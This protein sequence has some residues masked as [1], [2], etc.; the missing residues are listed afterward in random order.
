MDDF[1][2][3]G[4]SFDECLSNL[5]K[6]LKRFYR[7]FIRDFSKITRPLC[8]LLQKDVKF[9]LD[10]ECKTAF[11]LIKKKLISAPIIQPPDWDYPFEIMCDA[12]DY[13]VGVV[14]GQRINKRSHV[15]YYASKML[16][17]AQSNYTTT[18]K[19][20]LS[21]VYALD[22]FCP[23]LL[24]TKVIVY[25]DHA[26][27]RY[28]LSKKDAKPRLIRWILLLQEFDLE[29]K[30]K[31]GCENLFADH[32]SRIPTLDLDSLPI[33]DEFPDEQFF[34]AQEAY[35]RSR[36]GSL[37][38]WYADIVNF[39]ATGD[40]PDHLP[41]SARDKIQM[42]ES[43]FFWPTL[44]RDAYLCCK[45]CISCQ[46]TGN[47]GPRNQMPLNP[48]L[49]SK[50]TRTNDSKVVVDFVRSNIFVRYGT[51]RAIISDRGTHFCN[52]TVEA[53]FKKY[54]V[55]H[56]T[57][58]AYHPQ[59]NG[60]A[61]ISNREIKLILEKTVNPNR[62]DWSLRLD[63]ALWAYRTAYKTPI[64]KLRSRWV[65][66]YVVRNVYPHGVVEIE[67][68]GTDRVFKVNGHRLKPFY[69]G[70]E[71]HTIEGVNL[72]APRLEN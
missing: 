45:S 50:A 38:P 2:V 8:R 28:L 27:L 53:L 25:S 14:L 55:T 37:L 5:A 72:E 23:Y 64:G 31:K 56:R 48:I 66:P 15:I 32:L 17:S 22:K 43:G 16:D 62:K 54:H 12:S 35:P 70:F 30:D 18:E 59:N 58:T 44:F 51:P 52:R 42:L 46:K 69:E 68:L 40:L 24:G 7:R 61:E 39:L 47:I 71:S 63:D 21:I 33:K 10:D 9:E 19:E 60:Q 49:V 4:N 6:I 20:L 26:A 67:E 65:G 34:A 57:S 3:Y 11:D 36:T 29:I 1:T 41:K 13:A